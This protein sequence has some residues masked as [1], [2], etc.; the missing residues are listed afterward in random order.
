MAKRN[1]SHGEDTTEASLVGHHVLECLI[2]LG[3]REGLT[4]ALDAES[5]GES[6]GILRVKGVTGRPSVHRDTFGDHG[7]RVD[8]EVSDS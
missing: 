4:H 5:I 3:E 8:G 7:D 6:D 1:S 2:C